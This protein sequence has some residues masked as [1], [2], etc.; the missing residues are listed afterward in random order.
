MTKKE[1]ES[2]LASAKAEIERLNS[3]RIEVD[4]IGNQLLEP[5]GKFIRDTLEA[6]HP[7]T[8]TIECRF[9]EGDPRTVLYLWATV[10]DKEPVARIRQ[11][12]AARDAAIQ[13]AD[14]AEAKLKALQAAQ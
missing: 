6:G 10:D 13:R 14:F 11:L 3:I 5:L 4:R 9:E 7:L 1:L 12:A 8:T 2:Q